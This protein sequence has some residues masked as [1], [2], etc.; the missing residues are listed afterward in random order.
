MRFSTGSIW[1]S[2]R[3]K[4][5]PSSGPTA[6]ARPRWRTSSWAAR[7]I[8]L[9]LLHPCKHNGVAPLFQDG[10]DFPISTR[11]T[12]EKGHND[13]PMSSSLDDK[14]P[15]ISRLSPATSIIDKK[16]RSLLISSL[17]RAWGRVRPMITTIAFIC[18]HRLSSLTYETGSR[19]S[20]G[21]SR[22][23]LLPPMTAA[24][25]GCL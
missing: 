4:F 12:E 18:L 14:I 23:S 9:E 19:L 2:N 13:V 25:A 6:P 1:R 7:A 10:A 11:R 21:L 8:R 5:T 15:N 3:R 22:S 16:A 24:E 20:I 17:T